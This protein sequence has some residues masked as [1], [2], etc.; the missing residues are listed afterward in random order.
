MGKKTPAGG[1]EHSR[2]ISSAHWNNL[3]MQ[4]LQNQLVQDTIITFGPLGLKP[5]KK[6]RWVVWGDSN[7][8]VWVPATPC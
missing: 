7:K 4:H 1:G 2:M 3:C 5:G 6:S 8:M